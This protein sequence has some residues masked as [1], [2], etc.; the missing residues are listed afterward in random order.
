MKFL[1]LY[2]RIGR[3]LMW[4]N[5]QNEEMQYNTD[6]IN[7]DLLYVFDSFLTALVLCRCQPFS[8]NNAKH[9]IW[10]YCGLQIFE[11]FMSTDLLS[12]TV[13]HYFARFSQLMYV[14]ISNWYN[15]I[16]PMNTLDSR[17]VIWVLILYALRYD[18][19]ISH[20]SFARYVN[21]GLCMRRECREHFPRHRGLTIPTCITA[22]AWRTR[23]DACQDR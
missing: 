9:L 11:Q 2:R 17:T 3:T 14:F 6:I 13:T 19:M 22:R 20:G 21:C 1:G 10:C 4:C 15:H 23:L 5:V 16:H 12:R 18:G 8:H 7:R